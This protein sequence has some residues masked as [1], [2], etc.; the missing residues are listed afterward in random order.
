VKERNIVSSPRCVEGRKTM[1]E[2]DLL[3]RQNAKVSKR[4]V[5][6]SLLEPWLGDLPMDRGLAGVNKAKEK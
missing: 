6:K 3:P 2:K 5:R 1:K 4:G